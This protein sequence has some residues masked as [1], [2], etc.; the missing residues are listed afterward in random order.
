VKVRFTGPSEGVQSPLAAASVPPV[1]HA[2]R[3]SAEMART[4]PARV[5]VEIAML[6]SFLSVVLVGY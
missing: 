1:E 3:A 5:T 4:A 2:V 6:C